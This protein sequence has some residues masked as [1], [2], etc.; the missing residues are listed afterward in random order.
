MHGM[1]RALHVMVWATWP[2]LCGMVKG[3]LPKVIK[4]FGPDLA[5]NARARVYRFTTRES[6]VTLKMFFLCFSHLG[7]VGVNM[8]LLPPSIRRPKYITFV[9]WSL[10]LDVRKNTVL[11]FQEFFR[12]TP[13]M[14]VFLKTLNVHNSVT[15]RASGV[16]FCVVTRTLILRKKSSSRRGFFW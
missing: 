8:S 16:Q 12:Y 6:W 2:K 7:C 1:I 11:E 13:K 10:F 9:Y 15:V 3:L 5:T 14:G 4:K